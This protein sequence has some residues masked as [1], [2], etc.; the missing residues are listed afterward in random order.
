M[1]GPNTNETRALEETVPAEG[2]AEPSRGTAGGPEPLARG[3]TVGRYTVLERIGAGGMGVV[4]AA[5]DP[6]LDRRIA[7]KVLHAASDGSVGSTGGRNRLLREAQAM[8]KLHH[9][10]VITVHDVG[11]FDERVFVAMEFVD[12]ST[13]REWCGQGVREWGEIVDVFVRAGRGL[14]AAH[15]VGLVH[16]DFKPDNVL[17]GTDGRVLVMDFGLARQAGATPLS[18]VGASGRN[19]AVSSP[20]VALT[21]TGTLLG[22][23]AYMAPEQHTGGVIGPAV[24]QFSFCVAL[25]EALWGERPFSGNS[26][27]SLAIAVLEGRPRPPP[28]D[29]EV[30]PWLFG[31]LARGLAVDP[32]ER[33]PSMDAL[34]AELQ[35]DPPKSQ[36]PWLT[37]AVA[38]GVAVG[39]VSVYVATR[40]E[41]ATV[42]AQELAAR[43]PLLDDDGRARIEAA[44]AASGREHAAISWSAAQQRLL[45]YDEAWRT[46]WTAACELELAPGAAQT[47]SDQRACL[48]AQQASTR[49]LVEQFLRPDADVVDAAVVATVELDPPARC[50]G[51]AA[52]RTSASERARSDHR[53]AATE[54]RTA[55]QL[56][57]WS[58]AEARVA[59]F[60]APRVGVGDR[61]VE[62]ELLLLAGRAE[63]ALG[64]EPAGRAVLR[65]AIVAAATAGRRRLELEAWFALLESLPATVLSVDE[66]WPTITATEAALL[67]VGEEPRNRRRWWIDQG[68]V[69]MALGRWR[70]ALDRYERAAAIAEDEPLYQ[71]ALAHHRCVALAAIE[72]RTDAIDACRGAEEQLATL[73]GASHPDVANVLIDLAAAQLAA[74]APGPALASLLRARDLLD[75]SGDWRSLAVEAGAS[76]PSWPGAELPARPQWFARLLDREGQVARAQR[77]PAEAAAAHAAAA[78]LLTRVEGPQ[79]RALA[80][81]LLGLGVALLDLRRPHDAVPQLRR[82]LA[83]WQDTLADDHPDLAIAQLELGNALV[84]VRAWAEAGEHYQEALTAWEELLPA[85]HPMLAY[86]LTGLARTRVELDDA[87]AAIDPLERALELRS[88]EREDKLNVAE[89]RWWLA[90]A[91]F[92]S[93]ADETRALELATSALATAGLPAPDDPL[94]LRRWLAGGTMPGIT[95]AF[96]PASLGAVDRTPLLP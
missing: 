44:F 89:T 58:A 95:D 5:F 55:E 83:L 3:S 4:Y 16:R 81:P 73:L 36:R 49:L 18:E 12:G 67:G 26:V 15:A 64:R 40:P 94:E 29:S 59:G 88:H 90:R 21:R 60:A 71:A 91:L 84:G 75:P 56:R 22:T 68:H 47:D 79:A 27:A 7:L 93:G 43:T 39:I 82:A 92:V 10:N 41:A 1:S 33:H 19:P 45:R 66:S 87:S 61:A 62:A 86:A 46:A 63:V 51:P 53:L 69:A 48:E 80:Y 96:S 6:E 17:V 11:T 13:L 31:V 8:A 37:I 20:D 35:R 54:A 85:D 50:T 23:P 38:L 42:C 57:M 34:L 70:D 2:A 65:R 14:A 52:L 74:D 9:P 76:A 72:A 78:A 28:R 32:S 24:D 25:Y 30:P 77:R